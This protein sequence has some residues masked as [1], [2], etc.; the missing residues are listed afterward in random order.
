MKT[1]YK[2]L[3]LTLACTAL[4]A[5]CSTP[6]PKAPTADGEILPANTDKSLD[7]LV[8]AAVAAANPKVTKFT[9]IRGETLRDVLIRWSQQERMRLFY[10]TTF[11]P[12]LTGAVNEPD[13]RA[14][15]FATSVLLQFEKT[16]AVLDLTSPTAL[17]VKNHFDGESSQSCTLKAGTIGLGLYCKEA[18]PELKPATETQPDRI[19]APDST[20]TAP[21]PIPHKTSKQTQQVDSGNQSKNLVTE[22]ILTAPEQVQLTSSAIK[23]ASFVPNLVIEQG[24]LLS[25]SLSAWLMQQGVNLVWD[26]YASNDRLRDV[27][28]IAAWQ[29]SNNDIETTLSELL[30]SFG[31]RAIIQQNPRTVIIRAVS[32]TTSKLPG[33]SQ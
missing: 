33:A 20:I 18:T 15:A 12:V 14:A 21:T 1:P 28:M 4:L 5:A 30:P 31:M 17:L 27:E 23:T 29:S 11:N 22:N 13:I 16:G 25:T 24:Q 3:A 6:P 32:G 7:E 10:R 9:A 2:T 8:R 19:V 26:V